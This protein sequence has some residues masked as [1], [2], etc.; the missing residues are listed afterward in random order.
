MKWHGCRLTYHHART[1]SGWELLAGSKWTA[2]GW[3]WF[4][5]KFLL[6]RA[7]STSNHLHSILADALVVC[8][9]KALI[10]SIRIYVG[11]VG[12]TFLFR[13]TVIMH[14]WG[15]SRSANR[16]GGGQCIDNRT[17][18]QFQYA[19]TRVHFIPHTKEFTTCLGLST[20]LSRIKDQYLNGL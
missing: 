18:F 1:H 14:P 13:T 8:Q 11:S 16:I 7:G 19:I 20:Y 5:Y 9:C 3:R 12:R 4:E 10:L 15:W 17:S 6:L 2:L